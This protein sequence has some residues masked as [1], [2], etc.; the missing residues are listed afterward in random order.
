M[1]CFVKLIAIS[2]PRHVLDLQKKVRPIPSHFILASKHTLSKYFQY[3][4]TIFEQ[5]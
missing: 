4:C 3:G 1:V 5:N 2:I